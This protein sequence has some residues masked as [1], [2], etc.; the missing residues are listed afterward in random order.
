M[1]RKGELEECARSNQ[2]IQE[3]VS[4][5]YGRCGIARAQRRNVP[6]RRTTRKIHGENIVWMVRQA[7]RPGILG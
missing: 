5:G 4:T 3:R 7:V 1:G 2:R 6:M